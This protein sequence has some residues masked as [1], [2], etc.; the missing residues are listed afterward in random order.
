M[1][2]L[3]TIIRFIFMIINIIL[4]LLVKILLFRKVKVRIWKSFIPIYGDVVTYKIT[5]M[6]GLWVLSQI[7]LSLITLPGLKI[8][9]W[10]VVSKPISS[11]LTVC[12]IIMGS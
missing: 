1:D 5:G 6:S 2:N 4:S 3:T 11:F 8:S 9:L 12:I 10:V 7:S